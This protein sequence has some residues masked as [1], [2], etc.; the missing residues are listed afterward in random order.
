MLIGQS[1]RHDQGSGLAYA[2]GRLVGLAIVLAG[3]FYSTRW[4]LIL[5]GRKH[6]VGR[7]AFATLW[8]VESVLGIFLGFAFIKGIGL[9]FGTTVVVVWSASFWLTYR[10]LAKLRREEIM[11]V[12]S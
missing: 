11:G 2:I 5:S 12:L 6:K 8:C 3:L 9:L 4:L 1:T 7:Q 10:W